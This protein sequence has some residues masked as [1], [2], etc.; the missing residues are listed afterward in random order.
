[1]SAIR[2]AVS[3]NGVVRLCRKPQTSLGLL[4][5]FFGIC[6]HDD[7]P[8]IYQPNINSK[9]YQYSSPLVCSAKVRCADRSRHLGEAH[10]ASAEGAGDKEESLK[11]AP[12]Q[13]HGAG[14]KYR[15]SVRLGEDAGQG[16]VSAEL[17]NKTRNGCC[18]FRKEKGADRSRRPFMF[19]ARR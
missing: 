1:M 18:V 10:H 8:R 11:K 2:K 17:S 12:L 5:A 4:S 14:L 9:R 6:R 3:E 13:V 7:P 15:S 19:V 16:T